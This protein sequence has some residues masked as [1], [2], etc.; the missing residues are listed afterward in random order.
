ME[1]MIQK[2]LVR[3]CIIFAL[4]TP[5]LASAESAVLGFKFDGTGAQTSLG[6]PAL[7][8][9]SGTI[10]LTGNPYNSGFVQNGTYTAYANAPTGY[11]PSYWLCY[12]SVSTCTTPSFV[13]GS[14]V[15][16]TTPGPNPT[17]PQIT[18]WWKYTQVP[19]LGAVLGFKLDGAGAHT[20]VGTPTLVGPAGT[21]SLSGNPFNSG[22]IAG[23]TY[24]A[25]ANAPAGYTASYWLC[26]DRETSCT[27]PSFVIGNSVSIT[28]SGTGQSGDH[29]TLWWK[30]T[31]PANASCTFNGSI[32]AHGSSVTA[33][34]SSSVPSGQTCQSQQRTCSNG[35]LS[36]TYSYPTCSVSGSVP[37]VPN[38]IPGAVPDTSSEWSRGTVLLR[39]FVNMYNGNV[40]YEPG[41]AFPYKMWFF[42]WASQVCNS[43][44][45]VPGKPCDMIFYA[46]SSDGVSWQVYSGGGGSEGD[47]NAGGPKFDSTQTPSLWKPVISAQDLFYDAVHNGDP[48]VVK[49]GSTYYM[50]YSITGNDLDGIS[51][52]QPGDND[53]DHQA[54]MG[55]VS[56][57]GIHWKRATRPFFVSPTEA[58]N[59]DT[60][61]GNMYHRPSLMYENGKFRMWFDYYVS[62]TVPL[63]MG[64]AELPM[65][66]PTGDAFLQATFTSLRF[67]HNPMIINFPNPNVVKVGTTY[68]AYADSS[69]KANY[70]DPWQARAI[71]EA[72]S[73]DGIVWT[74]RGYVEPEA[75]CA[76]THVP[77]AYVI[78]NTIFVTYG[79]QRGGSPYD[80]KYDQIRRMQRTVVAAS[81]NAP[82]SPAGATTPPASAPAGNTPPTTHTEVPNG[83]PVQCPN[84]SRN[85]SRGS[86]GEDVR[87]LQVFLMYK[88]RYLEAGN[89][90]GYFGSLTE[91]AV[92][93]FQCENMNLCSGSAAS[94]GYG[95]V[96]P[97]TRAA[98]ILQ[99]RI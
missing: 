37:P 65:S 81:P 29:V 54:I 45:F 46:R 17:D 33:Y 76:A 82:F 21:I 98:I 75:G 36:G 70:G 69:V 27:T 96:G 93:K 99:C 12:G 11:T 6:S 92:K 35:T 40:L 74:I 5:F 59:R 15:S 18:L 68:Y 44:T 48:A 94:N 58:G 85:L 24:I 13:N 1:N 64:Y 91:A 67:G 42:G 89:A 50:V 49:V 55:A 3:V 57:D 30:Y 53:Q 84:L 86:R 28:V 25:Y 73:P 52:G 63:S 88:S 62:D 20:T 2:Y 60:A 78:G 4:F 66:N 7:V 77:E 51:A 90:T 95:A 34:Q 41:E 19:N 31:A 38:V 22:F 43:A 23:G 97:R 16:I 8:G 79:C 32:V 10:S 61:P 72:T 71:T 9:P 80:F 47:S 39:N 56:S 26:Y 87:Q 83:V 14:S